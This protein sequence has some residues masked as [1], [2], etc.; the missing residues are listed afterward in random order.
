MTISK[1][2]SVCV[3]VTI[4]A[5]ACSA[6]GGHVGQAR[7]QAGDPYE[8]VATRNVMVAARDG[9]TL[10]TDVYAPGRGGSVG[11][12]SDHRRAHGLQQRQHRGGIEQ[13]LRPAWLRGR[14]PR[15][16]A[17][18]T[19][20][21][22]LAPIRD[23]PTMDSDPPNGLPAQSWSNGNSARSAPLIAARPSTRSPIANA[24]TITGD[25]SGERHVELR[26]LRRAPQWRVRVSLANWGFTLGTPR[27]LRASA[28]G[29]APT[30]NG[31]LAAARAALSPEAAGA[32][33]SWACTSGLYTRR[34]RCGPGPRRSSSRPTM[35]LAD[36]GHEPRRQRRLL[37]PRAPASSIT[38]PNIRTFPSIT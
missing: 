10:A 1:R 5:V 9:V 13:L 28:T 15:T 11:G 35:S 12:R 2:A 17:A 21:G 36:R 6:F 29:L 4:V 22:A 20:G 32:L 37:D 8:I 7:T 33:R 30:P 31:A 23:D 26:T 16:C 19:I 14:S 38:L 34:C 25:G 3:C 18:D 24:P 27:E